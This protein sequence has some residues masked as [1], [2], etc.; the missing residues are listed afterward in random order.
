MLNAEF[1]RSK[2]DKNKRNNHPAGKKREKA[3]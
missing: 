3:T 2:T 1:L